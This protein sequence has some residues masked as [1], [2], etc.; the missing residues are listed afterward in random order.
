MTFAKQEPSRFHIFSWSLF[1]FA[2]TSFYVL[3]LTVSYPLYFTE[4]VAYGRP[5]GDF[6]WGCTFSISMLV[7]ALISPILGAAADAGTGKKRFLFIFT[8]MCIIAT[9]SLFLVRG[10]DILSGMLLVILANIGFEAGLVFYDSFLP[11]L[12]TERNYGK[13]SGYGFAMG[14]VGSLVTLIVAFPLLEGGFAAENLIKIRTSFVLAAVFFLMFSLP[15]FLFVRDKQGNTTLSF[16]AVK[17][18]LERVTSTFRTIRD[19]RNVGRFLLAYFF[20]IDAVNTVIIFS[21]IFARKTLQM[22]MEEIIGFFALVQTSAIIGAA[23]FGIV[24]D[25]LGQKATLNITLILW[26]CI[27]G[28]ATFINDKLAFFV[29]GFFAGIAMGSSQST[30]RS[31]FALIIP[32]EKKTEFFGFYSFFGKAAAILGPFIFGLISS[33]INQRSA[34]LSIGALFGVGFLILQGVK[35]PHLTFEKNLRTY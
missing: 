8:M 24:A 16:E 1:D 3:I 21:S 2:N 6:L 5:D 25:R 19:Y 28:A 9:T 7:V 15:L 11:E 14:Y 30:S 13:V 29:V 18:G 12:T 33:A 35:T 27:V 17:R 10:G 23:L 34:V 20:Y 31:L 32:L 26:L 22:D 4:I